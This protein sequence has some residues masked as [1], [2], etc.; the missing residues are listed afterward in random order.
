MITSAELIPL[1]ET[2][3]FDVSTGVSLCGNDESFYCELI[4]EL[5][6]NVLPRRHH[7]LSSPFE[8]KKYSHMLKGTLQTLGETRASL[9]ARELETALRN[10]APHDQLADALRLELDRLD[11]ALGQI[12]SSR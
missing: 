12:F 8:A 3:N 7:E 1:L 4:E 9:K 11:S 5:H 2:L 10:S 6:T